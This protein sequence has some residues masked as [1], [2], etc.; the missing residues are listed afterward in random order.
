M[1]LL[2]RLPCAA[3]L[4]SGTA[5]AAPRWSGRPSAGRRRHLRRCWAPDPCGWWRGSGCTPAPRKRP[6]PSEPA[7]KQI[8][9][10]IHGNEKHFIPI[11][12]W[13]GAQPIHYQLSIDSSFISLKLAPMGKGKEAGSIHQPIEFGFG[14]GWRQSGSVAGCLKILKPEQQWEQIWID[15][16]WI[17]LDWSSL[18]ERSSVRSLIGVGLAP[19]RSEAGLPIFQKNQGNHSGA[20]W[21]AD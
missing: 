11:V 14:C 18:I 17:R 4:W 7:T 10:L 5:G 19:M 21:L 13:F 20:N 16:R 2:L 8:N 6:P 9:R 3:G 1:L 15:S 12:R